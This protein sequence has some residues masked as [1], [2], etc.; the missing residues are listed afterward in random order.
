ML[1]GWIFQIILM[2]AILLVLAMALGEYIAKVFTGERTVAF[3]V[4][5]PIERGLYKLF[6]IDPAEEME[7]KTYAS[8]VILFT[9]IGII[10]LFLLLELQQFLPWNPQKIGSMRWDTALNAAVSYATH[11]N[12]Q[13]FN[14]EAEVSYLVQMLGF[15]LQNF[16]AA[17]IGIAV[18]IAFLRSFIRKDQP[19]IGNFWVDLT[20]ALTYILLPL[21]LIVSLILVSQGAVQNLQPN[22]QAH[23]LEGKTQIIAQGPAASQ[24]AIKH[25]GTN[26]GGFFNANS[27]HP[28]ENP[29]SLTD[30][31]ELISMLLIAAAMPFAF[32]ALANN[33]RQGFAIF[34]AMLILFLS[35]LSLVIYA[36]MHGSPILSKMNFLRPFSLEG[37]ETRIGMLGSL[38]C[39]Q[40]TTAS[41]TGAVNVML[42][43][44]NPLTGLV[45]IFNMVVGEVIF[46]GAGTGLIGMMLYALLS[47][48]LIGLM[49]GR[50]PEIFG[51]KLEPFEMIMAIIALLLPAIMQLV[52]GAITL[53]STAGQSGISSP[54]AQGITELI[55]AFA[56]SS[57]NNGSAMHSLHA[58]NVFYNLLL[59]LAM[60]GGRFFTLVPAL[61]I[62]GSLASK[63]SI[64]LASRFPTASPMFVIVL[65]MVVIVIGALTFFPVLILGPYLQHLFGVIGQTF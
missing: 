37:K 32:G 33:R 27:A 19:T 26:G 52:L 12:W 7:W 17:G 39:A 41:S 24:V 8:S 34:I 40:A 28:Y 11:T 38:F 15:S 59:S 64:P 23:T 46:G 58:N 60:F 20:R 48:F 10:A 61:A 35:G 53:S 56:S 54:G 65:M 36:E 9:I 2:M 55:Y 22:I 57:G 4:L 42:E 47:M 14:P 63:K 21:A 45:M 5:G 44:L 62:A 18:C 25:L 1:S 13:S 16:L 6:G 50:S 30:Y 51:K 3:G 29:N 49:I 43:S 31:V